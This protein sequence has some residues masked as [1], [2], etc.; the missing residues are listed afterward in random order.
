MWSDFL[1]AFLHPFM[2][3]S[4]ITNTLYKQLFLPYEWIFFSAWNLGEFSWLIVKNYL[5]RTSQFGGCEHMLPSSPSSH[6]GPGS[7]FTHSS[8]RNHCSNNSMC[9]ACLIF[10]MRFFQSF[11]HSLEHINKGHTNLKINSSK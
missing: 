7:G 2:S 6:P 3:W 10:S 5:P 11:V 4:E 9:S 1:K 8:I